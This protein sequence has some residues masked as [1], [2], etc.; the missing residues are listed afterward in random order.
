[1]RFTSTIAA[2]T[3]AGV[4]NVFYCLLLFNGCKQGCVQTGVRI[5]HASATTK[6]NCTYGW[7]SMPGRFFV[8]TT[9]TTTGGQSYYM[10]F[11]PVRGV[12]NT[13]LTK[14]K[15]LAFHQKNNHNKVM[16][17]T[18]EIRNSTYKSVNW[19]S[20]IE[21]RTLEMQAAQILNAQYKW[22]WL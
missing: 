3:F 14:D 18:D 9:T 10:Y 11:T 1:M 7:Q 19:W 15:K 12:M 5:P 6:R 22:L 16:C 2:E 8:P 17:D 20:N 13:R 21:V 4:S